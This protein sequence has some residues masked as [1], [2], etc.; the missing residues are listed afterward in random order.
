MHFLS[1]ARENLTKGCLA[2]IIILYALIV[3]T[4]RVNT[5]VSVQRA[6]AR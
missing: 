6:E 1:W 3:M 4:G 5:A 2:V